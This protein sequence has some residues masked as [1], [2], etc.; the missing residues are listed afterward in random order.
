M[1]YASLY[2][3]DRVGPRLR[4]GRTI[5]GLVCG[6]AVPSLAASCVLSIGE[7]Q[8]P[9]RDVLSGAAGFALFGTMSILTLFL[10]LILWRLPR[11]TNP[12]VTCVLLGMISGPGPLGY[13]VATAFPFIL[14]TT[15]AMGAF[16]GFV[17]WLVAVKSRPPANCEDGK[18]PAEK[19]S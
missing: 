13:F 18:V 4:P 15:F 1:A 10:P 14:V 2:L 19:P 3:P 12:V 5:L 11:A 17:F 16:G 9:L 6:V 8:G 7:E